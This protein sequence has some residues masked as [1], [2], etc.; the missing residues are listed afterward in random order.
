MNRLSL[1][2]RRCWGSVDWRAVEAHTGV[3]RRDA[4]ALSATP[5]GRMELLKRTGGWIGV[6][7]TSCGPFVAFEEL[8]RIERI[9]GTRKQPSLTFQGD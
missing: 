7:G 2:E 3:S 4:E 6:Y 1:E 8:E 9:T 5:K